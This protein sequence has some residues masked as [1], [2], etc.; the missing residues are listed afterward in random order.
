MMARRTVITTLMVIG[1]VVAALALVAALAPATWVAS[2][3][4]TQ[5]KGTMSLTEA[6][7]T[8]WSGRGTAVLGG[9]R[10]AAPVRWTLSPWALLHGRLELALAPQDTAALPAQVSADSHGYAL[11]ATSVTLPA[12]ALLGSLQKV[13]P[14]SLGGDVTLSTPG[15]ALRDGAASG[16]LTLRWQAAR[17]ADA[18]GRALDLGTI[19][20]TLRA[21]DGAFAGTLANTGGE[22]ALTGDLV[23]G[24]AG[25]SIDITVVPRTGSPSPLLQTLALFG[26]QVPGGGTRIRWQ[27]TGR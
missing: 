23:A 5:S 14:I 8:L 15:A 4:A 18:A 21:R 24:L 19:A 10:W 1:L 13:L 17:L 26:S 22:A 20:T 2:L 7:G 25:S 12:A 6:Q 16:E 11:A 9:G 27:S 3:I